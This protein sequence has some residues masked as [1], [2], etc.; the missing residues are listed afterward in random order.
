MTK[1]IGKVVEAGTGEALPFVNI[2]IPKSGSNL[3]VK[4]VSG[5]GQVGTT[6][7]EDGDFEITMPENEFILAFTM[8]GYKPKL[9][10]TKR[11]RNTGE[12]QVELQADD[13]LAEVVITAPRVTPKKNNNTLYY[14]LGGLVVLAILVYFLRKNNGNKPIIDLV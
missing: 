7:D 10:N 1:I 4:T 12:I 6:S 13:E 11:N 8:I 14:I 5:V 9:V 2:F 3:E